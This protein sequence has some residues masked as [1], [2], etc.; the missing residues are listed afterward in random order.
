ML[1][2]FVT[3]EILLSTAEVVDKSVENMT[4]WQGLLRRFIRDST[5]ENVCIEMKVKQ[6]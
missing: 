6:F 2:L 5:A 1:R 3:L 4:G